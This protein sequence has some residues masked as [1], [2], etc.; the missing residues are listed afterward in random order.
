MGSDTHMSGIAIPSGKALFRETVN[1][2]AAHHCCG[3]HEVPL[4][5][6]VNQPS[7]LLEKVAAYLEQTAERNTEVLDTEDIYHRLKAEI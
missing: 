7:T 3:L 1:P 4:V 5:L 2:T 6:S